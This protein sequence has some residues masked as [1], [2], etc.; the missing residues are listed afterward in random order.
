MRS[1]NL[2]LRAVAVATAIAALAATGCGKTKIVPIAVENLKPTVRITAAPIDTSVVCNP[3]PVRSCYSLTLNWVGHDPDGRVDHF[4]FAIDPPSAVHAETTWSVSNRNEERLLFRSSQEVPFGRNEIP[5]ARDYHVFVIKAVD[6]DGA[7]GPSVSRAF[8]SFTQAPNVNITNPLP[9]SISTPLLTPSVRITW[10][11]TDDDGVFHSKPVKYKYTLLNSSSLF[12]LDRAIANPDSLRAFYAPNFAGWD[13]V[14]G[15]TNTVQY[16]NLPPNADYM[17]VIVAFDEAGAYS[18]IFSLNGNMLRFRVGFAGALGPRI[19][20]FNEFFNYEWS[21]GYCTVCPT[22]ETFIEVPAG[23][24]VNFNWFGIPPTGADMRSY[25]WVLDSDDLFDETPRDD[26]NDPRFFNHWSSRSLNITSITL[27]PFVG[28]LPPDPPEEHRLYIE[29]EDNVGFRSLGIIRFQVVRATHQPGKILFV[30]DTRL[31]PENYRNGCVVN[32]PTTPW[33]TQAELDTFLFARGNTPWRCYPAGSL[34]PRGLFAGYNLDTVGTRIK[35]RDLTVR[36][37]VLSKYEF[38]V[39]MC[40][41][42]GANFSED[43]LGQ[44]EPMMSLRYMSGPGRF[45]TLGAYVKDGGKVWLMGGGG[46]FASTIPWDDVGNNVPTITFSMNS[47]RRELV[48]GRFMFDLARWQSEFRASAEPAFVRRFLGRFQDRPATTGPSA[49]TEFAS[50]L[51]AILE[52][53]DRASDPMPPNRTNQG[54][55]YPSVAGLEYLQLEN[56]IIENTSDDP[57]IVFE[58]STLDTIY[59]ASGGGLPPPLSNPHNVVMTYYHGPTVPHGFIF[60]GFDVWSW[61][62]TQCQQFCDFVMQKMWGL[63]RGSTASLRSAALE[64]AGRTSGSRPT[65]PSGIR[66]KPGSIRYPWFTQPR[67][68]S[69]TGNRN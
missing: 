38:V 16:T 36:L 60:T 33:P 41:Q 10:A 28:T 62:R 19:I 51:P 65:T 13:S 5:K 26:E 63:P 15:D 3:D 57:N 45:N 40:D 7:A 30:K 25:R 39:W 6:N 29:A 11:G 48:P 55:F 17:F 53:K 12:S 27:G 43:G 66:Q 61:K 24:K 34:T 56:H 67:S 52:L 37:S 23:R 42:I 9:S 46:A 54:R 59:R 2:I 8:F 21:P 1:K 50:E 44:F 4:L 22:R 47:P 18:P 14:G 64:S 31:K 68:K 32:D 49:Y 35:Q 69:P 58:E 20:A